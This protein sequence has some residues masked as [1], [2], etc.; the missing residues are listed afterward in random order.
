MLSCPDPGCDH[1]N[2]PS[3]RFCEK[4]GHPLRQERWLPLSSGHMMRGGA[5]RILEPLGKG[6]MGALYL[7]ADTG[8]FDRTCVVKELLDYYDPTDPEEARKAQARFETEARLRTT[9]SWNT[10]RARHCSRR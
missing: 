10:S 3:A 1:L 4:C 6:G 9:S 8:A 5:Y 2:R 7:A